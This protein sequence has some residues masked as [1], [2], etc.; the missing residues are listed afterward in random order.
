VSG[1]QADLKLKSKRTGKGN[2]SHPGTIKKII[3]ITSKTS[4]RQQTIHG[5]ALGYALPGTTA[6]PFPMAEQMTQSCMEP[7]RAMVVESLG[8]GGDSQVAHGLLHICVRQALLLAGNWQIPPFLAQQG[9]LK[10]S[11]P[12][13]NPRT[14]MADPSLMCHPCLL[15]SRRCLTALGT[16]GAWHP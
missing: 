6:L 3:T 1:L 10:T 8:M 7:L 15:Q 5:L 13:Q 16:P 9:G 11:I 2:L 4:Q 14:H 12:P